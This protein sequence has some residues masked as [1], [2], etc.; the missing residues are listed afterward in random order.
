MG[1]SAARSEGLQVEE[2]PCRGSLQLGEKAF[3]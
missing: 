3:S 1:G 2:K